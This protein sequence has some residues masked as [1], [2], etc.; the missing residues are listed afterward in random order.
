M[1][2]Y[3]S[4]HDEAVGK[5][6]KEL[7]WSQ[8]AG[9]AQEKIAKARA[10]RTQVVESA[11]ANAEY[12]HEI[13]PEYRK[14]PELVIQEIYQAAIEQVLNN[15]DE[16]FIIQPVE[17]GKGAEIRIQLNRDTKLKPKSGMEK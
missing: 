10:Y 13:L 2:L 11:K 12:L 14:R 15:A 3:A 16:K 7:L 17:A 4:L 9:A 1:E 5:E 8:L 6:Q